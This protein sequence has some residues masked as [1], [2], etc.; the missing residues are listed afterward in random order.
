MQFGKEHV[1]FYWLI[2]SVT[3]FLIYICLVR[4]FPLSCSTLAGG[5]ELLMYTTGMLFCSSVFRNA[6]LGICNPRLDF[7]ELRDLI[8]ALEFKLA[9]KALCKKRQ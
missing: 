3:A 4:S 9:L 1:D 7:I 5:T 2:S 6:L 8:L